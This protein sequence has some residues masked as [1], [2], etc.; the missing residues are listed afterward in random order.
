MGDVEPRAEPDCGYFTLPTGADGLKGMHA[1][2]PIPFMR[3]RAELWQYVEHSHPDPEND[4]APLFAKLRGYDQDASHEANSPSPSSM[5]SRLKRI[6]ADTDVDRPVNPHNFRH[7]LATD[8][9]NDPDVDDTEI[10][11]RMGWN[12]STL[13]RMKER[14][15]DRTHEERLERIKANHGIGGSG[16]LD[17]PDA[18]ETGTKSHC[19]TCG[20]RLPERAN[21]CP[22][23]GGVAQDAVARQQAARGD[24]RGGSPADSGRTDG[25]L[26]GGARGLPERRGR[27]GQ[28]RRPR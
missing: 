26:R 13:D 5:R 24:G 19:G 23:C 10:K 28:P 3:G 16:D 20:E 18:E 4:A 21:H 2:K 1:G 15:D 8:L 27:G 25:R 9:V 22:Q 6:A 12:A 11:V 14:Y 7:A 17:D